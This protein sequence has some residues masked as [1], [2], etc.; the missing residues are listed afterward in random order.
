M[1]FS[2]QQV[3]KTHLSLSPP[4]DLNHF[5]TLIEIFTLIFAKV[6]FVIFGF[7]GFS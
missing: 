6:E 1:A 5:L 4:T 7:S 3:L 2:I